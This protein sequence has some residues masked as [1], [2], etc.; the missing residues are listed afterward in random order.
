MRLIT[1]GLVALLVPVA[2]HAQTKD[3]EPV[4][5][6][7][8]RALGCFITAREELGALPKDSALYLVLILQDSSQ[9]RSMLATD[10]IPKG[11]C[12]R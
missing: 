3:C 7:A 8:G 5:Q 9:P 12:V 6:R 11:L 4:S 2:L 1:T 10:W